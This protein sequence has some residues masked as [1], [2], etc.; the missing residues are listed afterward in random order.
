MKPKKTKRIPKT[1]T[2]HGIQCP[3]CK[4][5]IYSLYR[6]DFIEC[7]CGECF[8]DGGQDDYRRM[9]FKDVLPI[10]VKKKVKIEDFDLAAK[11]RHIGKELKM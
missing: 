7:S 9:G 10:S 6:H 8:I 2:I 11:L 1:R 4:E 5:E 3:N